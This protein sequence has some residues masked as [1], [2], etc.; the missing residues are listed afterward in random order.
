MNADSPTPTP[1][2]TALYM[3]YR[4][5]SLIISC[6]VR[7][8]GVERAWCGLLLLSEITVLL[9]GAVCSCQAASQQI[10]DLAIA[11]ATFRASSSTHLGEPTI[12]YKHHLSM[13]ASK[14][15]TELLAEIN[16]GEFNQK[17]VEAQ[18]KNPLPSAEGYPFDETSA[19]LKS[20]PICVLDL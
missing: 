4:F 3:V 15:P 1:C 11:V 14:A 9:G 16:K 12:R 6:W 5:F 17:H 19:P 7:Y 13:S 2:D 18:E 8:P 10:F 20:H